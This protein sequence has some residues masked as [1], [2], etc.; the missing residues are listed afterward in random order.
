MLTHPGLPGKEWLFTGL[1]QACQVE[2]EAPPIYFSK[3]KKLVLGYCLILQRLQVT[4]PVDL[5]PWPKFH[6]ELLPATADKGP[7]Q[8]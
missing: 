8:L 5:Q 3:D 7:V 6:K 2:V 1:L 4:K